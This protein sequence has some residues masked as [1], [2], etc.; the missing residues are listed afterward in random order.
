MAPIKM[1]WI[2]F[3]CSLILIDLKWGQVVDVSKLLL[4]P[5]CQVLPT[6]LS[7]K[8]SSVP[9]IPLCSSF[10]LSIIHSFHWL[11]DWFWLIDLNDDY[12]LRMW[13]IGLLGFFSWLDQDLN[14]KTMF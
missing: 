7:S 14:G 12:Y 10:G 8:I 1:M 2:P 11:G 9:V 3:G 5:T 13:M 6:I 4:R